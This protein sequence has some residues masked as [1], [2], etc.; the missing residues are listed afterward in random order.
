MGWIQGRGKNSH[1]YP[2]LVFFCVTAFLNKFVSRIYGSNCASDTYSLLKIWKTKQN[3]LKK[4]NSPL[5]SHIPEVSMANTVVR[6]FPVNFF[7]MNM[8]QCP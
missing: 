1:R 5:E 2:H 6:F 4:K 8:Q 7:F 3:I